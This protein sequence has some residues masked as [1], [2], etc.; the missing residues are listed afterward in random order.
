MPF[1]ILYL[2]PLLFHDRGESEGSTQLN[3]IIL[4]ASIITSA[5][6]KE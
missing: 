4:I 6:L 1:G 3:H 2:T 5:L